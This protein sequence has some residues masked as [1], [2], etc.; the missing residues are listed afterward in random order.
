MART[1]TLIAGSVLFALTWAVVVFSIVLPRGQWG[2]G[3]L[4]TI[5][6][7]AVRMFFGG[8]ARLPEDYERKDSILAPIG[9][10]AVLAQLVVW[11]ALFGAAF[12]LMLVT[13]T[14][15]LG[16]AISQA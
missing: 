2:P 12:V 1:L 11:L 5:I 4:S 16:R 9:P 10:V 7:R 3:R 14:H 8:I 6:T 15:H 13:Y